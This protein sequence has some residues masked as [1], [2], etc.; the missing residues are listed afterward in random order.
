MCREPTLTQE[1]STRPSQVSV[2]VTSSQ[3]ILVNFSRVRGLLI[4]LG[5]PRGDA[6]SILSFSLG[7]NPKFLTHTW[8]VQADDCSL[9][10]SMRS[11]NFSG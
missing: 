3:F 6:F 8:I 5:Y 1:L 10:L 4:E 11:G 2:G 9:G 7:R